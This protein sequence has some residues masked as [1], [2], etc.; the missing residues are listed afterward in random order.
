ME[1]AIAVFD[2]MPKKDVLAWTAMISAYAAH[3]LGEEAFGLLKDMERNGLKPNHVT[4]GALLTATSA[5]CL[6]GRLA[7]PSRAFRR[8]RTAHTKHA[9]G[10]G[11]VC[12]GALLGACRMHGNVEAGE[13]AAA[14]LIGLDP[15][16][17]AYYI[18]LSDIYARA[19][20]FE[21][22]KK[23]RGFMKERGIKKTAPGCSMIE[24]DGKVIEFSAKWVLEDLKNEIEWVLNAINF[25]L[26][27]TNRLST[28]YGDLMENT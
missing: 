14:Q 3:G 23:V 6:H 22:V 20:R 24:V 16:N 15:L 21:D 28:E 7:G 19:N 17:H 8:S 27:F 25:E 11:C 9:N 10:A 1:R 13:R 12:L 2:E 26:K 4:F 18:I 5:L